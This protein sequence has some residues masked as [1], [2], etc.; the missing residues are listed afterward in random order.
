VQ[1]ALAERP[2][3]SAETFVALQRARLEKA[4]QYNDILME[5]GDV[6]AIAAL[7]SLLPHLDRYWG[8]QNALRAARA[9]AETAQVLAPSP[10][11][12]LETQTIL[13]PQPAKAAPPSL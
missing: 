5:D 6:R 9:G 7:A 12:S 2:P 3:E 11:K 8:L 13:P 1:H 10:L 4:L